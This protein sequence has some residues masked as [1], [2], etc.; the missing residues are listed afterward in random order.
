ML[1]DS[2]GNHLRRNDRCWPV[3]I[4]IGQADSGMIL[5]HMVAELI[6]QWH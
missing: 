6:V 1:I 4:A 3:N 5:A 2:L